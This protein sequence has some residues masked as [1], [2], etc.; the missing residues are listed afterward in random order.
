MTFGAFI[1]TFNRPVI[2]QRTIKAILGQT[3]APDWL[4][5][6]DNGDPAQTQEVLRSFPDANISYHSMGGNTGPAGA[7]AYGLRRLAEEG[8]DWIYWVDDDD[9]PRTPDTL[10]RLLGLAARMPG[11]KIGAV[12]GVGCRFDWRNG[13][14]QR[15]SDHDLSGVIDVDIIAGGQQLILHREAV[16][17]VGVADPRLFFGLYEPEYCLRIR[18][19]GF[20]LLVDGDYMRER[21]IEFKRMERRNSRAWVP[22]QSP[23]DLW[24]RY[25]R[26]RNYIFMMR[27]T[28]ERPDL[29]RREV[30]KALGRT[31]LSTRRGPR[32]A[33]A[34]MTMQLRGVIDGYRSRMGR[35]VQPQPKY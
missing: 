31:L 14:M 8:Y 16:E 33:A 10:E 25:Y 24:Q 23:R 35:T 19:S 15:L 34:F 13:E 1:I 11:A 5:V 30:V 26:T 17:A 21:R 27:E 2:L 9:P 7:T 6:V 18:R 3:R 28:F 20:R 29:A 4:L 12:G 22:P 32:Y